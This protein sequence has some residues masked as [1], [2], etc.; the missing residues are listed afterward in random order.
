MN[1]NEETITSREDLS[2]LAQFSFDHADHYCN[3]QH[4]CAPYHKAWSFLRLFERGGALPKGED[5]YREELKSVVERGGKRV[6]L[7]GSADTGL[8]ALVSKVFKEFDVTP[9]LTLVDRCRTV[10][11]QNKLFADSMN[12]NVHFFVGDIQDFRAEPFDVIIAHSFMLFFPQ[13]ELNVL[14]SAWRSLLKE[15][16]LVL[17]TDILTLSPDPVLP[18][19]VTG[20]QIEN[21]LASVTKA[22]EDFGMDKIAIAELRRCLR[23]MHTEL[24]RS[25][26]SQVLSLS[27]MSDSM[28]SGG[29][30]VLR[31]STREHRGVFSTFEGSDVGNFR[32]VLGTLK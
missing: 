26:K 18:G 5:F 29:L 9:E 30:E 15:N 31:T 32:T 25:S 27:K 11:E 14:A 1:R 16:G 24:R 17:S 22:A 6:L 23:L 4:G 8:M 21:K 12:L 19:E 10:I 20:E 13:D 2:G 28:R 7:S 3:E